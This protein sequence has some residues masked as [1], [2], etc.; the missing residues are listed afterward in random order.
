MMSLAFNPAMAS[1]GKDQKGCKRLVHASPQA[2]AMATRAISAS[3]AWALAMTTGLCTAH[4]PPP[5]GTK[6]FTIPALIKVQKA[7]VFWVAKETNQSEMDAASPD[8]I[9]MAIM[10]A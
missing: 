10:P 7:S 2:T 4:C 1:T 5:E 6:I 9:M 3:N 8:S